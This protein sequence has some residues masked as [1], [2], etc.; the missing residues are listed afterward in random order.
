MNTDE[1]SP[2]ILRA[3]DGER[4][5]AEVGRLQLDAVPDHGDFYALTA[6][7]VP[8]LCALQDVA[9]VLRVQV[10]GYGEGRAVY[11][12]TRSVDPAVRLAE[13]AEQLART[14]DA[15]A[16]AHHHANGFWSE[17]SHI[18]IEARR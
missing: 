14:R 17:I 2:A 18:G 5:W 12:D 10:A 1:Q 6:A 4:A 9:N 11:D 13:A 7:L 16:A 8:T 15:L 3:E